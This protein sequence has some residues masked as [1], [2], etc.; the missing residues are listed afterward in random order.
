MQA[1]IAQLTQLISSGQS[2]AYRYQ[3]NM[4]NIAP[5]GGEEGDSNNYFYHPEA[6]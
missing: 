3:M 6:K 1:T 5:G 4:R 2:A